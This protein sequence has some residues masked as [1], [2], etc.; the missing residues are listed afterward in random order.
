MVKRNIE[1][2]KSNLLEAEAF[3]K[4][5]DVFNWIKPISGSVSLAK[6]NAGSAEV[7]CHKLAEEFGVILLPSSFMG[8]DDSFVRFGFGR[9]SFKKNLA[10][11]DTILP[12][13]L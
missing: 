1:I 3:F 9:K 5:W 12:K 4:K 7:F 10:V 13:V 6:I 2:I 8:D 11:L